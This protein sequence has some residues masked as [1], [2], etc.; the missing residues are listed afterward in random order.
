MLLINIHVKKKRIRENL[1]C[2]SSHDVINEHSD[3]NFK[4]PNFEKNPIIWKF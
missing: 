3:G 4:N 1:K 2:T